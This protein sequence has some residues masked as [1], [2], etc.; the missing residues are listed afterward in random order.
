M[1]KI[2][3]PVGNFRPGQV[4]T[5]SAK[6]V[7]V[8]IPWMSPLQRHWMPV[9]GAVL[10]TASAVLFLLFFLLDLAGFHTNP[11]LGIVTFVLVPL[12]FG[13]GLLLIPLGYWCAAQ[14]R[15]AARPWP[16]LDFS[17]PS[18][19]RGAVVV[20]ALTVVNIGIVAAA[21]YKALEYVD[22]TSF[23]TAV[24]H[25]VMQPEAVAHR[26]SVHARIPCAACHVGQG[27]QGFVAAKL[28]GV[29]RLAAQATATYRRPIP[30][31]LA[32]LP[33]TS[34]TCGSCHTPDRDVGERMRVFKSYSNDDATTEQE[35]TIVLKVG[36]SSSEGKGPHGIHWHASPQVRVEYV[37][38]DATQ[39]T[40]PWVRV[41]DPR[42]TREYL[43]E[44]ATPSA[45]V[46]GERRVMDCVDCH[47]RTGHAIAATAERAVDEALADGLLPRLPYIRREATA[48]VTADYPDRA[49]AE[50]SIARALR[51]FY[52]DRPI[53]G[54]QLEQAIAATTRVYLNNVFPS[55]RVTFGTYPSH[56]GHTDAP[57]CFRCHDDRH[58]SPSGA[59]I[60]Q[61]C[62]SCHRFP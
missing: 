39:K 27:P 56:I 54:G 50:Q 18:V 59:V 14:R 17:R 42:G 12:V 62:E 61:D 7:P 3:N 45:A 34:G 11:Y 40:I 26:N 22:S 44:G 20:L 41:T 23:C 49:A 46:S 60:S 32:D 43:A 33:S 16:V 29:R 31:P 19:R 24:C 36:S 58:A 21:S 15:R 37:A 28:D 47:N 8:M 10:T 13:L 38:T 2:V 6:V 5:V 35:S 25:T 52:A 1:R 55:M 57:G 9:L 30:V 4:G 53:S 48:A 51:A